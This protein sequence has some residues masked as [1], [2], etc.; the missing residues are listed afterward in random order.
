MKRL[1]ILAILFAGVFFL[2]SCEQKETPPQ[3]VVVIGA[4]GF[5][6]EV[7]AKHKEEFPH[8]KALVESGSHTLELRSVLPS[9]SAANWTSML[10]GSPPEL[11]GFTQATSKTPEVKPR[12]LNQYGRYPGI[13]GLLRE[14][15]TESISGLFFQWGGINHLYD[16]GSETA[17][18]NGTPEKIASAGRE[19][20]STHSPDLTFIIFD[21]PDHTGHAHGWMSPEY[22]AMCKQIDKY[23]GEIVSTIK[24]SA[25][26]EETIIFFVSD[27]GGINKNHG[28]KSMEEMQPMFAVSGKGV[29]KNYAMQD[30]HMIYDITSTIARFLKITQPQAWRGRVMEEILEQESK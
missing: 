29:K 11:H 19:F 2:N 12:I 30:V 22:V 13:Y 21:E 15:R 8:I 9:S 25:K 17:T 1:F 14:Q 16:K 5:S 6:A 20:I 10:T 23:V 28:G 3:P 27:H 7:Y 24:T 26:G 4:D 18:L